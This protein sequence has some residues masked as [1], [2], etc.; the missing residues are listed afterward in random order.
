MLIL[1]PLY[2]VEAL[3]IAASE[4]A[5]TGYSGC[6]GCHTRG[7]I[8]DGDSAQGENRNLSRGSARLLQRVQTLR[9]RRAFFKDRREQ[10]QIYLLRDSYLNVFQAMARDAD[11]RCGMVLAYDLRRT[12]PGFARKVNAI[13]NAGK[14]RVRGGDVDQQPGCGACDLCLDLFR[15]QLQIGKVKVFFPQ[16]NVFHA[17]VCPV[18]R[19]REQSAGV[20]KT[21]PIGDSAKTHASQP[22]F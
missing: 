18:F 10:N 2:I 11:K 6:A 4:E 3:P 12:P 1:I 17:A 14:R 22:K 7:G 19:Q 21:T 5:D 16:L 9:S 15:Q 20:A 8:G 13:G